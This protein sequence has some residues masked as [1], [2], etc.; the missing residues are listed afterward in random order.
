MPDSG[1]FMASYTLTEALK[2]KKKI[3]IKGAL[4]PAQ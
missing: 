2:I 4:Q 3:K 1:Q